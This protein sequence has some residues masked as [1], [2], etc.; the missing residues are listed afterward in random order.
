MAACRQDLRNNLMVSFLERKIPPPVLSLLT[1]LFMGAL[2]YWD[3]APL[4][5]PW[6]GRSVMAGVIMAGAVAIFL[7][8]GRQLFI[9]GTTWRPGDPSQTTS[10]VT[11]GLYC[12]SRNPI[13]L[14]WLLA[15]T[16]WSL[17][18]NDGLL[19]PLLP[20]FV[21]H[22]NRFQIIPEERALETLFSD[23][24]LSYKRRVRRWA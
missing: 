2:A 8:S 9:A 16:A 1:A 20:A 11:N 23:Q 18:L 19:L 12:F 14:A 17:F 15:L 3:R 5:L 10:L 6:F 4:G 24:Y 21:L 13:Y 22:M 7:Y